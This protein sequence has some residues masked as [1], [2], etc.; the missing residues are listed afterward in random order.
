TFYTNLLAI[1]AGAGALLA[2]LH[3]LIPAAQTHWKFAVASVLLFVTICVGLFYMGRNTARSKN[4]LA[5]N[6]VISLSVF[7]KMVISVAALFI[8]QKAAHPA[9]EWFVAI[10]LLTYVVYTVFEVW[11]MTRLAKA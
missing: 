8:Y 4:K 6:N 2:A 9:N 11:F 10:F 1:T 3:F 7:G 5:F